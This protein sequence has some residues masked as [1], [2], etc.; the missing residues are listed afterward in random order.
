M[1]CFLK[2]CIH[3]MNYVYILGVN[4]DTA[5]KMKYLI[6]C[7]NIVPA[8]IRRILG[9]FVI[10]LAVIFL[11]VVISAVEFYMKLLR[12]KMCLMTLWRHYMKYIRYVGLQ[13]Q[14]TGGGPATRRWYRVVTCLFIQSLYKYSFIFEILCDFTAGIQEKI[15]ETCEILKRV[16]KAK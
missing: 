8:K 4:G 11:S 16:K 3:L 5:L 6:Y 7:T 10:F 15:S 14:R 2:L 1:I 12:N 13:W 9:K